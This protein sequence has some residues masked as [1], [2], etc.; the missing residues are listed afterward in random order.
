MLCFV[1]AVSFVCLS[2]SV[3]CVSGRCVCSF[4]TL[5]L[6]SVYS[7]AGIFVLLCAY[8]FF[9]FPFVWVLWGCCW[10]I[11]KWKC[12]F[13][14]FSFILTLKRVGFD[15]CDDGAVWKTVSVWG[16]KRQTEKTDAHENRERYA[17]RENADGNLFEQRL[18]KS[19]PTKCSASAQVTLR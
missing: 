8:V 15:V 14:F 19:T 10:C 2:V 18:V 3:C 12:L 6:V 13:F 4:S 9:F 1:F 17:R 5:R 7:C 16:L 11:F